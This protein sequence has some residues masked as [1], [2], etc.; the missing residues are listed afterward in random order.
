MASEVKAKFNQTFE[1]GRT[2]K[3]QQLRSMPPALAHLQPPQQ[4]EEQAWC[5]PMG[6]HIKGPIAVDKNNIE[7]IKLAAPL[8]HWIT[9]GE[10]ATYSRTPYNA[11]TVYA[12]SI[13]YDSIYRPPPSAEAQIKPDVIITDRY[14]QNV[15]VLNDLPLY[16]GRTLHETLEWMKAN[17][18]RQC[19]PFILVPKK[20]RY[21]ED[22]DLIYG[23][24][25]FTLFDKNKEKTRTGFG[26]WGMKA[27]IW[28]GKSHGL[29][30]NVPPSAKDIDLSCGF[31]MATE[32]DRDGVPEHRLL[33]DQIAPP[34][35][36]AAVKLIDHDKS[37]PS[38]VNASSKRTLT[39]EEDA[40]IVQET[41][42]ENA[43][44][45]GR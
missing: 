13:F 11:L 5:A 41:L 42:D 35:R 29:Y 18:G 10:F 1:V 19:D 32:Y 30:E 43:R 34:V 2:M 4:T 24:A 33:P 26:E 6:L 39:P 40:L 21:I 3:Q 45:Q 27:L 16:R 22:D 44:L 38:T 9:K 25:T 7:S 31:I 20:Q 14:P 37:K 15:Y 28:I 23:V 12:D 17:P 8:V 36:T